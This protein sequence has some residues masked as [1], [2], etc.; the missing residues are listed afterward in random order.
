MTPPR[1]YKAHPQPEGFLLYKPGGSLKGVCP[2][3]GQICWPGRPRWPE[4]RVWMMDLLRRWWGEH[5]FKCRVG[6]SK[7]GEA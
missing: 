1:K 3:C 4:E 6:P 5:L 7:V 2:V